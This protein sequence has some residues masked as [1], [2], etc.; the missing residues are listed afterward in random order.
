MSLGE[1]REEHSSRSRVRRVRRVAGGRRA[2]LPHGLLPFL[3]LL[4]V[5]LWAVVPFARNGVEATAERTATAALAGV[6]AD[7]AR[8]VVSGQ[9]VVLEGRAPSSRACTQAANAVRAATEKTWLGDRRPVTRVVERCTFS[10]TEDAP[11][12]GPAITTTPT[13]NADPDSADWTFDLSAD[14]VLTL[15][16]QLPNEQ[17][18][19]AIATVA[20]SQISPPR[21]R[22][23]DD[24][25]TVVEQNV[26]IGY[27]QVA[28]RG[29]RTLGQ[30]DR[31]RSSFIDSFF[32]L[33]C[34]LPSSRVAGV[35][36]Q[37]FSQL[38]MG[39][40]GSIEILPRET[41]E[42]CEQRLSDLLSVTRIRFETS[43]SVIADSSRG[44]LDSI[45]E[46]AA[47]C[48]GTLRIG[49]HTDNTGGAQL[50]QEL[51][52]QRA[53]AVRSA[54]ILRGIE[55]DRLVAQGYGESQPI[56]SNTTEAGRARNRRIEIRVVRTDQ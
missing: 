31:G 23:I 7:W 13:S 41:V 40:V 52:F 43:S 2:F 24:Q 45:A 26:P 32:S 50:N 3:G 49:G 15:S 54:L 8:P 48:P 25:M 9:R 5:L 21:I 44:L 56:A 47:S 46:A 42:S 28:Q 14:G 36:A 18:R 53:F 6:N 20:Q 4:G 12:S 17:T 1:S 39:K 30:C 38:P 19:S 29:L 55:A 37:A 33:R 10:G 34:E 11:E 22:R 35:E 16:G 51:S 27:L